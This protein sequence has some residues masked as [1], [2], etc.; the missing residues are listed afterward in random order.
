[1][2]ERTHRWMQ[3]WDLFDPRAATRPDYGDAVLT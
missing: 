3:N 1:M 2:F